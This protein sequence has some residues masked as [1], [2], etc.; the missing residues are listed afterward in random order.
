VTVLVAVLVVVESGLLQGEAARNGS[1]TFQEERP[2]AP[3]SLLEVYKR[4]GPSPGPNQIHFRTRGTSMKVRNA[5]PLS[6]TL[7]SMAFELSFILVP[8]TSCCSFKIILILDRV[9]SL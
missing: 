2:E 6:L 3:G 4:R 5:L 7:T 1:F 9:I 8:G